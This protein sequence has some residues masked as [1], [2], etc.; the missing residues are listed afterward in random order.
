MIQKFIFGIAIVMFLAGCASLPPLPPP[1]AQSPE[2]EALAWRQQ[3]KDSV[4]IIG[5][6]DTLRITVYE[7]PD[8]S[9]EV[10]VNPD[11]AFAYPLLERVQAA[12]LTIPELEQRMVQ[13]LAA[14]YL[15]NPQ[16]AITVVQSRSQQVYVLGAVRSPGTYP[17]RYGATL[18]ELIS[19]AGGPTPEAGWLAMLVRDSGGLNGTQDNPAQGQGNSAVIRVELDKLLSGEGLKP[20][21]I[22]IGDTIYVPAAGR[23]FV[24]GQV[25]RP[26]QYRLERG[27]TVQRAITLAGGF[28]RFAAKTRLR[29]KRIIAGKPQEFQAQ[30][31]DPLQTEDIVIVPESVF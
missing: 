17:L 27:T 13:R 11:G 21:S 31:D 24:S 22:T 25:E 9:Q 8:L 16:L 3:L 29:V 7:H 12:G 18:L 23:F 5:P 2:S 1:A 20:I 30:L 28:G 10:L 14:E 26:G 4:Y 19:Q 6:A 15:V